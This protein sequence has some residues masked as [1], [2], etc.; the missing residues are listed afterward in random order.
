[1]NKIHFKQ[2]GDGEA[3]I[4]IHGLFG[5]LEN[6]GMINRLLKDQFSIYGLDLPNHGG[7]EHTDA[8]SIP[9]M[10]EAIVEW[11]K[12]NTL[13]SAN[14]LGHSLGGKVSMEI[15][16]RYPERVNKLVVADI[17]PVQYPRR[18]DE[19]FNGLNSVDL[20]SIATRKEAEVAMSEYIHEPSIR[21]FLLKNLQRK[22]E[23]WHWKMN[24]KGLEEHYETFIASNASDCEP[25]E[26]PVLFIKGEKSN[27]I[28]PEYKEETVKRF[29][30]AQVKVIS[31]TEHWLHAEKPEI[32]AGIVRRFLES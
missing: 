19:V 14:F 13:D 2:W 23:Q 10:A 6:L 27:Y 7:S 15:A 8:A 1:M 31:D 22:D 28:L 16:L 9:E 32:F 20:N 25:F 29:P 5:T 21:S 24:L 12:E 3:L 11:M 30:N 4:V 26:K 17:A 18:H